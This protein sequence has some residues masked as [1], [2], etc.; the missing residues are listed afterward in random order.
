MTPT[1]PEIITAWD[2]VTPADVDALL[3][4]QTV[5]KV[6]YLVCGG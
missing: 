3:A 6:H 5:R 1:E 2:E 4:G